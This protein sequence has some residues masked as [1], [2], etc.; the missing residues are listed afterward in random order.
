MLL[1]LFAVIVVFISSLSL[2]SLI[3]AWGS[4]FKK[5]APPLFFLDRQFSFWSLIL[6]LFFP[7]DDASAS[8]NAGDKPASLRLR[9]R[10]PKDR[11]I[12]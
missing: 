3:E 5:S 9:L 10:F 7:L 2:A 4:N 12:F 1:S 6:F 11:Y 8:E